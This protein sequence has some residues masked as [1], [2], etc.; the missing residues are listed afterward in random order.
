[1]PLEFVAGPDIGVQSRRVLME[2]EERLRPSIE[3]AARP[4][5]QTGHRP[6]LGEQC[7][8]LVERSGASVFHASA[9]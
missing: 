3:H 9:R 4:F 5:H 6:N 1:V 7:L 2:V 8:D